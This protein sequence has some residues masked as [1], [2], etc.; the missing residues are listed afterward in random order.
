MRFLAAIL[1]TVVLAF[2]IGFYLAVPANPEVKFW[3][4][5]VEERDRE[6]ALVRQQNPDQPCIFFAGGS[7]T[8]F[9]IDPKVIEEHCGYPAFN[10][11][12]PVA[13]GAEYLA[14]HAMSKMR[15]GDYLVLCLEP[16]LLT[17]DNPEPS[18]SKFSFAMAASFGE[19]HLAGGGEGFGRFMRPVDYLNLP[20]PGAGY[21]A[22]LAARM[23]TGK[24]YRYIPGD[25]RYRGRVETGVRGATPMGALS[26]RALS[27]YGRNLLLQI[28]QEAERR[29][30]HLAYSM[31]WTL[32]TADALE[33]AK[34]MNHKLLEEISD[35]I[36]VIDGDFRG[37]AGEANWFSDSPQHL[38]AE[39]SAM[40]SGELARG[41]GKWLLAI[42]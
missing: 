17:S 2:G 3:K 19:S 27:V 1:L 20:R 37:A 6:L 13:A 15:P 25:L 23:V 32:F 30:I 9:S 31:P 28:R 5:V 35:T 11:G 18:P 40:R 21:L 29:Q 22:T 14:Y 16:G 4:H 33:P 38:T 39:G 36:P 24:G 8:A 7:S 42:E 41:I 10:L 34:L 12:L 26:P